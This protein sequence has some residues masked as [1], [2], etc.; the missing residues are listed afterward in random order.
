MVVDA[1]VWVSSLVAQDTHHLSSR[2]WLQH[3]L[4]IGTSLIV[5]TLVL[6]E[7]AGA[8]S[9]RTAITELGRQAA[10]EILH[11]PGLRLVPLDADLGEEAARVAADHRLRGADAVY[12][13][14]AHMLSVPLSTLDE[15][16]EVRVGGFIAIVHP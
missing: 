1:S 16:L 12:V 3:H 13:A 10:A 9:R 2:R 7:V 15:E 14:T 8:I 11:V 4:A 5:P 6:A